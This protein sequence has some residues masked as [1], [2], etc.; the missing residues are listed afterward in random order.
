MNN[1][2][3]IIAAAGKSDRFKKDKLTATLPSGLTVLQSSVLPFTRFENVANIFLVVDKSRLDEFAALFDGFDVRL[4]TVAGG[5]TRTDSV[6]AAL[7]LCNSKYVL[8]HDG[9][10]PYVTR[11]LITDVMCSVEEKGSGV[12]C[13]PLSDSL[14][15]ADGKP[16]DRSIVRTVQTPQGFVT[17]KLKTAYSHGRI[18]T[19]DASLFYLE[20]GNVALVDGDAKNIKIT[21]PGDIPCFRSGVGYDVH[22]LV[23]GRKLM[24]CGMEIPYS[25][26]LD[27]HSDADAPLHA[28][29]DAALTAAGLMDI[30]HYFPT[31][32]ARYEGVYSGDLLKI[33][34]GEVWKA[35]FRVVNATI[36]IIAEKP[37]LADYI[38][39]M[40]DKV[41]ELLNIDP[42]QIG[43]SATTNEKV[44]DIG[45]GNAIA[46]TASVLL[47][48]I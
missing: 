19:D 2:D 8:I 29:A 17:E 22:R 14:V 4:K 32:D 47:T 30:G 9:A 36:S 1:F 15:R 21:Y 5:D 34:L 18:A 24:L 42:L 33:A 28:L 44:G 10:R 3:V 20:H 48:S 38:D 6:N 37:K 40:K 23:P 43:I 46:A 39:E 35:G 27:G 26:G 16:V 25:M 12:P 31:T 13:L 11:Q 45:D 7:S 41:A